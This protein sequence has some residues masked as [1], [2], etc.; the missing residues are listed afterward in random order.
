[1]VGPL[2][3]LR[4]FDACKL[5]IVS[6]LVVGAFATINCFIPI[7]DKVKGL[8]FAL[9]PLT[10]IFA[11][12]FLDRFALNKH[13][14]MFFSIIMV[15]LY[16]DKQL[17]S[18]FSGIISVFV[19]ILYSFVPGSFLGPEYNIPSLI[20]VY[21]VICGVLAA[22]YF[23]TD[24]GTQLILHATSKEQ[25]AQKL[26]QQLTSLIKGID[27]SVVKLNNSTEN[28]K[29]NIDK[30]HEGSESILEAVGHMAAAISSEEQNITE[31]NNAIQFSL[32]NMDKTATVS[33][34]VAAE[35]QKMNSDMQ[36]NWNKINR[37]TGYMDTLKD[38]VDTTA[39]TVDE[40]QKSLQMVDS[41]LQGIDTPKTLNP[42]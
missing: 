40:L 8:I 11:L 25:E 17:I 6:G 27:Q 35:S 19:F 18:I 2:I 9:L 16:F 7:P 38:S 41:L 23:L 3:Y 28:V 5:Y 30:I 39:S 29:Q 36:E 13:Y 24:A 26:V 14:I 33:Q 22:L 32:K 34:E 1:M 20:T 31:V 10:V 15:A 12:F 4:G 42:L 37:V 21:S